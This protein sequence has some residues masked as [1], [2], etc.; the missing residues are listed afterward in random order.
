VER[1]QEIGV[2]KAI[3]GRKKDIRRIF[4]SESFL[5]GLFSGILGVG[6]AYLITVVGNIVVENLFDTAILNMTPAFAVFGIVT[7][8]I[9]SMVAGLMPA[10]KAARLDPVEALRHD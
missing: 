10:Q 4:V 9:I 6:I 3:G 8:V 1:T 2:I 7:S 5:I